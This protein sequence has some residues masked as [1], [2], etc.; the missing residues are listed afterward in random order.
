MLLGVQEC[1]RY[2]IVHR[3]I[4]LENFLLELDNKD[5]SITVKLGDF[6]VARVG[7]RGKNF[8]G[9]AGTCIAMAPEMIRNEKYSEKVDCW[10]LGIIL[11]EILTNYL[12]FY[13]EN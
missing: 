4:K 6:G 10:S 12:P 9:V 13:N 5:Q 2:G 11:H 8:S 7:R 3:D 1:H